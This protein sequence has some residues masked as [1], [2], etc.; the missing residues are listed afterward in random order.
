MLEEKFFLLLK[1]FYFSICLT[2]NKL[3]WIED[4]LA[5]VSTRFYRSASWLGELNRRRVHRNSRRWPQKG[6]NLTVTNRSLLL[7]LEHLIN[8]PWL[9]ILMITVCRGNWNVSPQ[10]GTTHMT[11]TVISCEITFEKCICVSGTIVTTVPPSDKN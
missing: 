11:Y 9:A 7:R 1:I 10:A 4:Q 2:S 6:V 8:K 3:Y 5:D